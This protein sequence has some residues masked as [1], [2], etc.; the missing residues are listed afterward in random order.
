[1]EQRHNSSQW[2]HGASLPRTFKVLTFERGSSFLGFSWS[3]F[4][5]TYTQRWIS[6]KIHGG[7]N[8]WVI[9]SSLLDTRALHS[10]GQKFV[11]TP[12]FF[13]LYI[14]IQC[15]VQEFS[16]R[17]KN[18]IPCWKDHAHSCSSR[19]GHLSGT[20]NPSH[21]ALEVAGQILALQICSKFGSTEAPR[22]LRRRHHSI[23]CEARFMPNCCWRWRQLTQDWRHSHQI[24]SPAIQIQTEMLFERFV[25][26][27]SQW[28]RWPKPKTLNHSLLIPYVHPRHPCHLVNALV[29]MKKTSYGKIWTKLSYVDNQ[30]VVIIIS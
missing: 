28:V 1:M 30:S 18:H 4:R 3:P 22:S 29:I 13:T 10:S 12:K 11:T 5:I 2:E 23:P 20:R 16:E 25:S 19:E 7:G 6:T 21:Q 15:H 17:Y 24:I 9:S 26:C 8:V 14:Y 27:S